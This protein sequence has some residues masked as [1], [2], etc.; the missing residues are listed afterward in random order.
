LASTPAPLSHG[1]FLKDDGAVSFASSNFHASEE[2]C[3]VESCSF[4]TLPSRTGD[5]SFTHTVVR[6]KDTQFFTSLQYLQEFGFK[7]ILAR[8]SSPHADITPPPSKAWPDFIGPTV[9]GLMPPS[10]VVHK[11][12]LVRRIGFTILIEALLTFRHHWRKFDCVWVP[13]TYWNDHAATKVREF[14]ASYKLTRKISLHVP[15]D[16]DRTVQDKKSCMITSLDHLLGG[17]VLNQEV[18]K[19]VAQEA[20]YLKH[21]VIE[22]PHQLPFTKFVLGPDLEGGYISVDALQ[23]I[24][25]TRTWLQLTKWNL[26][27]N[28]FIKKITKRPCGRFLVIGTPIAHGP[29][30]SS[31]RKASDSLKDK[32]PAPKR[33]KP[34]SMERG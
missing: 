3:Q 28:T 9:Q 33:P 6:C 4:P 30:A 22:G 32:G 34:G 31:K 1:G 26:H 16:S 29:K 21:A 12:H 24:L 5:G 20:H 14:L 18:A 11:V 8:Q 10:F 27:K 7:G 19:Q 25:Q 17:K 2:A 23:K 13:A 15:T